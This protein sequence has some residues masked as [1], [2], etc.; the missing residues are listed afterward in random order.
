MNG[1]IMEVDAGL[2]QKEHK[3]TG[4]VLKMMGFITLLNRTC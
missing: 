3:C 1:N 4:C 2:M